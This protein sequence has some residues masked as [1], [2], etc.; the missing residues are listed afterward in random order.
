MQAL[1]VQPG[2]IRELQLE[3]A[4]SIDSTCPWHKLLVLAKF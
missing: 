1:A 2:D 3:R 4:V